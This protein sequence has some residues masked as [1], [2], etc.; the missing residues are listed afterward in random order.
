MNGKEKGSPRE[1]KFGP[2]DILVHQYPTPDWELEEHMLDDQD[3]T[4]SIIARP[5]AGYEFL[6]SDND[7]GIA[8]TPVPW[9]MLC[10][11]Q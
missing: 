10:P 2:G 6:L 4:D 9:K 11:V 1:F 7:E 8:A 5:R 3:P